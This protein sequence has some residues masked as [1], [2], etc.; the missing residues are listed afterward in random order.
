MYLCI[1]DYFV[2]QVL[3]EVNTTLED[4]RQAL[5][6]QVSQLLAQYHDLLTQ[7]L[8]DKHHYHQEEKTFA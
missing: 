1:M 7:T 4:A 6:S 5:M 3:Q 2:W 8:D